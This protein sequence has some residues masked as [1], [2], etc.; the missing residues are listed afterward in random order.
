MNAQ[1]LIVLA[2]LAIAN[3][4]PI[5]ENKT[6]KQSRLPLPLALQE[7]FAWVMEDG[8]EIAEDQLE[9]VVGGSTVS[10]GGRPYQCA[11]FRSGSFSCGCSLLSAAR[12][13]TA[14]HC[15]SGASASALTVGVNSLAHAST[16][17]ISVSAIRQHSSYNSNTIDYDVSVLV[18][19]SS[20]SPGTNAAAVTL[21]A[22][23][24]DPASGAA[25]IVSGWGRTSSGGSISASLLQASLNIVAR[26]TCQSAWGST[27]SITARMVCAHNSARSAC[28]GDSG[29]PLTVSGTQVGV[30][31]WGPSSCVSTSLPTAYASVGNL[32]TWINTQMG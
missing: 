23:G 6:V 22:S 10:S 2:L 5:K 12:V 3:A 4:V 25:A 15:T 28:N 18:L 13:L 17:R 11:L 7:K 32:R 16:T 29:G 27:N 21:A 30:V 14:A 24:S 8:P 26:A 1:S 20:W 31:S 9:R 19:A